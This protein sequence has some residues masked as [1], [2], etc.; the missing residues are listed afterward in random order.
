MYIPPIS[1]NIIV[2]SLC[3]KLTLQPTRRSGMERGQN[4]TVWLLLPKYFS[5][6]LLLIVSFPASVRR[7]NAPMKDEIE[8]S[9][10]AKEFRTADRLPQ[11]T[12][13]V[14]NGSKGKSPL[15][16]QA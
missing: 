11:A 12:K 15:S 7:W 14:T 6:F 3:A 16:R 5:V 2:S 13:T 8:G 4:G 10:E 9:A 1:C